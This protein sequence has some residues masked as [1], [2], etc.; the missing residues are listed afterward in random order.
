M[1]FHKLF[2]KP[3]I[4]GLVAN[5]NTGK[6]NLIYYLIEEL[7]KDF[8]FSVYAYGLRNKIQFVREFNS[9]EELE[10]IKDSLIII[11]ERFSL[12]DLDNRKIKRKIEN[13]LRLVFHN[14][15]VILLCGLGENF[16][17]FLSAKLD[18]IIFKKVSFAELVNGSRVKNIVMNY[19]GVERGTAILALRDNEA[20]IFDGMHYYKIEVPYLRQYD[21]KLNNV[22]IFVPKIKMEAKNGRNTH[23]TELSA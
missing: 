11:D 21:T 1:K 6:S 22:P 4:V 2:G 16:K 20:I 19:N 17:K 14:N 7:S 5:S 3:Q 8:D 10:Q 13:T 23:R 18:L 15:N 12:F 9:I